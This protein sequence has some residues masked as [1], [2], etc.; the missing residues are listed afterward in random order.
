MASVAVPRNPKR[1]KK[2]QMW[3]CNMGRQKG[4]MK[5]W[6]CGGCEF[7]LL[8]K[9]ETQESTVEHEGS[10]PCI[11]ANSEPRTL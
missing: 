5:S 1:S 3:T 6:V 2:Q 4:I 11:A 7:Q 10:T 8:Q 9:Q